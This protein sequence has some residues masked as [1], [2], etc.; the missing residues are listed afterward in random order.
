MKKDSKS[1]LLYFLV[2]SFM[3]TD[4]LPRFLQ[5]SFMWITNLHLITVLLYVQFEYV[6]TDR[7]DSLTF[8]LHKISKI[9][10]FKNIFTSKVSSDI[11]NAFY[12]V[13]WIY[14]ALYLV[15]ILSLLIKYYRKRELSRLEKVVMFCMT[16][17]HISIGFWLINTFLIGSMSY[18]FKA[19]T[20]VGASDEQSGAIK[21]FHYILI[22]FHYCLGMV[23]AFLSY[24][25]FRSSNVVSVHSPTCQVLFFVTKAILLPFVATSN[26]DEPKLWIFSVIALI[27]ACLRQ[28]YILTNFPFYY[29]TPM[30]IT[31]CLNSTMIIIGIRNMVAIGNK[32]GGEGSPTIAYIEIFLIILAIKF[33]QN[34]LEKI[35]KNSLSTLDDNLMTQIDV[36]KRIFARTYYIQKGNISFFNQNKEK[37]EIEFIGM[38]VSY[39]TDRTYETKNTDLSNTRDIGDFERRYEEVINSMIFDLLYNSIQRMRSSDKLKLS[40]AYYLIQQTSSLPISITCLTQVSKAGGFNKL[41]ALKL[42]DDIERKVQESYKVSE[43]KSINMKTFSDLEYNSNK[44][45][46]MIHESCKKYAEFWALYS[47]PI[48]ELNKLF[49]ISRKL[50]EIDVK[51]HRFWNKWIQ[52]EPQIVHS[53]IHVYTFYLSVIRNNPTAALK[54]KRKYKIFEF[55]RNKQAILDIIN[56]ENVYNPEN[57]TFRASLEKEGIGKVMY[58]SS[59]LKEYLGWEQKDLVGKNVNTIMLPSMKEKH[60]QILLKY[61]KSGPIVHALD[62]S[63]NLFVQNKQGNIVLISLYVTMYPYVQ[64]QL[65]YMALIR[66]QETKTQRII[67]NEQG[68]TE[69]FT[70]NIMR[71][72]HMS[73]TEKVPITKFCKNFEELGLYGVGDQLRAS[74]SIQSKVKKAMRFLKSQSTMT[75]TQDLRP[76]REWMINQEKRLTIQLNPLGKNTKFYEYKALNFPA[77]LTYLPFYDTYFYILDLEDEIQKQVGSTDIAQTTMHSMQTKDMNTLPPETSKLHDEET[78]YEAVEEDFEIP[79]ERVFFKETARETVG[80]NSQ[81]KFSQKFLTSSFRSPRIVSP[82][83]KTDFKSERDYFMATSHENIEKSIQT[84]SKVEEIP[85]PRKKFDSKIMNDIDAASTRSGSQRNANIQIENALF[86]V[87]KEYLEIALVLLFLVFAFASGGFMIDFQKENSAATQNIARNTLIASNWT[88]QLSN[89]VQLNQWTMRYRLMDQYIYSEAR[90]YF[91]GPVYM[92]VITSARINR[93]L[94]TIIPM[95][96]ALRNSVFDIDEAFQYKFYQDM[97]VYRRNDTNNITVDLQANG[98]DLIDQV[99]AI[100]LKLWN[101]STYGRVPGSNENIVFIQDNTLNDILVFGEEVINVVVEDSESKLDKSSRLLLTFTIISCVIGLLL[102]LLFI[103][104]IVKTVKQ[105]NKMLFVMLRLNDQDIIPHVQRITQVCKLFEKENMDGRRVN[106]SELLDPLTSPKSHVKDSQMYR[107]KQTSS[108]YIN[109]PLYFMISYAVI[110]TSVLL[111]G[112]FIT[113]P[114]ISKEKNDVKGKLDLILS[115]DRSQYLSLLLYYETVLYV[116]QVGEGKLRNLTLDAEW[117]RTIVEL[118]K[119]FGQLIRLS[120]EITFEKNNTE[121]QEILLGNLCE[122]F[123]SEFRIGNIYCPIAMNNAIGQGLIQETNYITDSCEHT[124]QRFDK[125]DKNFGNIMENLMV[126]SFME[127]EPLAI[128]FW[129][130]AFEKLSDIIREEFLAQSGAFKQLSGRFI[131]A[132]GIVFI[133]FGVLGWLQIFMMYHKYRLAW[134]KLI[135]LVPLSVVTHNK[136]MKNYLTLN[137][138]KAH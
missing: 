125:S 9:T 86:S 30:K 38:C 117:N 124:K 3:W 29:F 107:R 138:M 88:R 119:E 50:E 132:W 22:V 24:D 32:S 45:T 15:L 39:D 49:Q 6:T 27:F 131:F 84:L 81:I 97:P 105:R 23:F 54:L 58:V 35:I 11:L 68:V 99:S 56:N 66:I 114:L 19:E 5:Y 28:I 112:Y 77:K 46:R 48:V 87:P 25:P 18:E 71:K 95:N 57:I 70:E 37:S 109:R 89:L 108:K 115:C 103:Y 79:G 31:L 55:Q 67:L 10:A 136:M 76:T 133:V 63:L 7:H 51:I 122:L 74:A 36:I 137:R 8:Y 92:S 64:D 83:L 100:G 116:S 101:Q 111:V 75:I 4:L 62:K 2:T 59:N 33:A 14:S 82:T 21:I 91:L 134:L 61:L 17:F 120:N 42:I 34:S 78:N 96:S 85:T 113:F 26:M 80:S 104:S 118:R 121:I 128:D 53:I 69:G 52:P 12:S 90:W 13:V 129:Y 41:I 73:A 98:F 65:S 102:V 72:L 93:S 40:L 44:L 1:S 130:P 123:I 126:F 43:T 20:I 16:Q 127:I 110:L 60:D 135:R 106:S 94:N 47:E